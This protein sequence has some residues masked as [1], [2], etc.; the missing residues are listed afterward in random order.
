MLF[1]ISMSTRKNFLEIYRNFWD[2]PSKIF[3]SPAVRN[4]QPELSNRWF[5]HI[6]SASVVADQ[7][8]G[9]CVCVFVSHCTVHIQTKS[10]GLKRKS[11]TEK[12]WNLKQ[13][14]RGGESEKWMCVCVCVCVYIYI[15]IHT[16]TYTCIDIHQCNIYIYIYMCVCVC[17]CM[18]VSM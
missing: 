15:Y 10:I 12:I 13:E 5:P 3:T 11:C 17:V 6:F 7:R 2:A 8:S 18:Y 14:W 1:K 9:L 16:Y 4:V